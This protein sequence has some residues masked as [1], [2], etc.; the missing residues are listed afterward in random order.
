MRKERTRLHQA[1][2][3]ARKERKI[4]TSE[5]DLQSV[6]HE[7]RAMADLAS[8]SASDL[9]LV[10]AELQRSQVARLAA[11][12][13]CEEQRL[14]AEKHRLTASNDREGELEETQAELDAAT[15][16]HARLSRE[17]AECHSEIT[18]LRDHAQAASDAVVL[19]KPSSLH[20]L[21][22]FCITIPH[23]SNTTSLILP[24]PQTAG[25]SGGASARSPG[26]SIFPEPHS[27]HPFP[28]TPPQPQV[29]LSFAVTSL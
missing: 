5:I 13:A 19:S 25:F 14:Q 12:A 29:Y 21:P 27:L 24:A 16:E 8:A 10:R 7:L 1:A 17:L 26:L 20:S 18:V 9:R 28:F 3:Q 2:S 4:E 23:H 22:K 15:F 6:S 11:L